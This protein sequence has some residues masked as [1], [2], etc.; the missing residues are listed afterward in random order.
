MA[1]K[2]TTKTPDPG[3]NDELTTTQAAKLLGIT[4]RAVSYHVTSG[5]I[6]PVRSLEYGGWKMDF[7]RRADVIALGEQ[8]RPGGKP[9]KGRPR[10]TD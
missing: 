6:V 9:G 2:K 3:P 1:R 10:K 8:L 4:P 7:F 5:K